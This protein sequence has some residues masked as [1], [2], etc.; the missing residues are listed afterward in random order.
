MA[1]LNEDARLLRRQAR[2]TRLEAHSLRLLHQRLAREN[3]ACREL[4]RAS[5]L[6]LEDRPMCFESAW[7]SLPWH[8]PDAGLNDALELLDT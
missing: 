8:L 2:Q 7:S 5:L 6:L 4:C 3:A 1:S